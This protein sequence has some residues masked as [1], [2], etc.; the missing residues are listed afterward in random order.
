M[1]TNKSTNQQCVAKI[2][3][4]NKDNHANVTAEF[5]LLRTLSQANIVGVLDSYVSS[6][7]FYVMY[8]YLSG[9][10]IVQYFCLQKTYKEETVAC[11]VRQVL[12][13]LQYL[14]HFGII[15]LNL[16]PTS[17]VMATRRRPHVKLRDFTLAHKVEDDKGVKVP[18]AGYLD[19][20]RKLSVHRKAN[21]H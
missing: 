13:A 17:M 20:T 9:I 2:V 6:D 21:K 14:E 4:Y 18:L 11:L 19:F 1:C 5:E 15:H 8:E 7:Q 3:P 12:D 16:Q 10:N